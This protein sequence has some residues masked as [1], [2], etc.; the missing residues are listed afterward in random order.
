[1]EFTRVFQP[2]SFAVLLLR[3]IFELSFQFDLDY[4]PVKFHDCIFNDCDAITMKKICPLTDRSHFHPIKY[5]S[6][7]SGPEL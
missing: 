2:S 4:T 5:D 3:P 1:M 6:L 7:V